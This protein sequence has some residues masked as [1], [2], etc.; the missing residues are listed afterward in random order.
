MFNRQN[1]FYPFLYRYR[2]FLTYAALQPHKVLRQ[3]DHPEVSH[4]YLRTLCF[5]T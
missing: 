1:N 3:L 2:V 4:M 5:K